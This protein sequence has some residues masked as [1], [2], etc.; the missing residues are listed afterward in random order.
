MDVVEKEW[1]EH[2]QNG[3]QQQNEMKIQ[4]KMKIKNEE[5]QDHKNITGGSPKQRYIA[6]SFWFKKKWLQKCY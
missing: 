1:E 2:R 6:G 5:Q 4:K 3:K